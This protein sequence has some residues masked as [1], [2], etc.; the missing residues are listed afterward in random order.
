MNPCE[1]TQQVI[2]YG[3][4]LGLLEQRG[5]SKRNKAVGFVCGR[6]SVP[7]CYTLTLVDQVE[8][9]RAGLAFGGEADQDLVGGC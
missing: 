4:E 9:S 2:Y 8:S 5:K 7:V 6:V 3:G 1:I